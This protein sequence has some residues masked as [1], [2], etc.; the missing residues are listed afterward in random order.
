MKTPFSWPKLPETESEFEA[1]MQAIDAVLAA[2]GLKP[3]QRPLNVPRLLWEAFRW[4]GN[5]LPR[6][7]L[8][9][10]AG[11]KG[12]TLLAKAYSW[13]EQ[14]YRDKLKMDSSFAHIPV[15]L[16][17][18]TWRA[19]IVLVY[20]RVLM[21]VDR[22]LSNR[23]SPMGSGRNRST[24]NILCAVEGLS[25][26]LASR[27]CD[28]ELEQY[29]KLTE[30]AYKALV[31]RETLP[32]TELLV[33]ARGD[34]SACTEDVLARRTA[35]ARWSA[36]QALEKTLKG[37]LAIAGIT[38][39]MGGA[40][41][42][43]LIG[44]AELLECGASITVETSDLNAATCSAGVR[45]G[46]EPSTQIQALEANHA[47]VRVLLQLAQAPSTSDLLRKHGVTSS[48]R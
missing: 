37:L 6:P 17:H 35:Q 40:K 2:R 15:V 33:A 19:R 23:G 9:N 5:I 8:V 41:G 10:A 36:Q 1:M 14:I 7:D 11:F 18:D 30:V 46:E 22:D 28:V 21:F 44:L 32:R 43:D 48:R 45:Y 4:E 3:A 34:Y 24:F 42:H 16:G 13:Y 27:L 12:Q 20:G 47:V 38:Y 25:Q 39:P 29:A 26:A 31:W